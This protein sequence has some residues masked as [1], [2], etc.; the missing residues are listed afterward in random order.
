MSALM[1]KISSFGPAFMAVGYTIGTG[2]VTAM[3]VAGSTFGMQLLWVLVLSC[4]F[5]GVWANQ[6]GAVLS[7]LRLERRATDRYSRRNA[8]KPSTG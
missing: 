6:D 4:L 5:S 2:S 8:R 7:L 1:K 3:I